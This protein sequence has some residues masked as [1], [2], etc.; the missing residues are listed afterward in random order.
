MS[1]KKNIESEYKER[2]TNAFPKKLHSDL[3]NILKILPFENN[4]VQLCDITPHKVEN[5]IHKNELKLKLD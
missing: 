4:G 5:L 1:S 3:K 2:L